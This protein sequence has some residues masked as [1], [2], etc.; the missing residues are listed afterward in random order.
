MAMV[1]V[2]F[3]MALAALLVA[4][5]ALLPL[6]HPSAVATEAGWIDVCTRAG[7]VRLPLD[8]ERQAPPQGGEHCVLCRVAEPSTGAAPCAQRLLL[9]SPPPEPIFAAP[10]QPRP[11]LTILGAL[12]RAP[13]ACT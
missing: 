2:R 1:R 5:Q 8:D 10:A 6:M 13:P 7:I 9:I 3:H 12:A 4:A 11:G